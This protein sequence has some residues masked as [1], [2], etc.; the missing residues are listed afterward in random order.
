MLE[1]SAASRRYQ[2]E[3]FIAVLDKLPIIAIIK[4]PELQDRAKTF[5]HQAFTNWG[6]NLPTTRDLHFVTRLTTFD[7]LVRNA[8]ILGIPL[9]QLE[10]EG[11]NSP[12]HFQGPQP[13]GDQQKL[14]PSLRPSQLQQRNPHH[15]WVDLFPIPILRDNILLAVAKGESDED[16][17]CDA[18]CHDL[19]DFESGTKASV[20]VWG[21]SWDDGGWEFTPRF[22]KK[23][24]TLMQRC[25]EILQTADHL[26]ESR[27]ES[28]LDYLSTG[29][30]NVK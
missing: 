10:T 4:C 21:E 12:F 11:N 8:M 22:L 26:R 5:L 18:L 19:F 28:S 1:Q 25:P 24:G 30:N 15:C 6:L 20:L 3:L 23:W 17:L 29:H 13:A 9:E 2:S 7:A 27:S 14:P 16:Q